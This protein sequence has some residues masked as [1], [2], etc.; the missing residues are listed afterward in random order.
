VMH[1]GDLVYSGHSIF[2]GLVLSAIWTY[3]PVLQNMKMLVFALLTTLY[4]IFCCFIFIMT[5]NHYTVDVIIA[6]WMTIL[7][8]LMMPTYP[9]GFLWFMI[10]PPAPTVDAIQ[11]YSNPH[12]SDDHDMNRSVA[13]TRRIKSK[14]RVSFC[15]LVIFC[16]LRMV[17]GIFS[18]IDAQGTYVTVC[19]TPDVEREE[20]QTHTLAVDWGWPSLPWVYNKG[21]GPFCPQ[22]IKTSNK[23]WMMGEGKGGSASVWK[24]EPD[25]NW[26]CELRYEC[27]RCLILSDCDDEWQWIWKRPSILY[28]YYTFHSNRVNWLHCTGH[29]FELF[30]HPSSKRLRAHRKKMI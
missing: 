25:T 21:D 24:N 22:K 30:P 1:C 16:G 11:M 17:F 20:R 2:V 8:W 7:T 28:Q 10:N 9:H 5:Q 14:V 15:L 19:A 12:G 6:L 23:L 4:G 3:L 29:S 18:A 26:D 27:S 13:Q